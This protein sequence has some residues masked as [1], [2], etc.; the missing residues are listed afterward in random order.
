MW[1]LRRTGDLAEVDFGKFYCNCKYQALFSI[2]NVT[3]FSSYH[4]VIPHI[5]KAIYY[6][7]PDVI[8]KFAVN[9]QTGTAHEATV[10]AQ[11]IGAC[12]F[13]AIDE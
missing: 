13:Y 8:V 5:I 1:R 12:S 4:K 11:A 10:L 9:C 6:V 3:S 7:K 2:F